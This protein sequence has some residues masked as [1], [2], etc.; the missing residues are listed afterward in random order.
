[1]PNF[2]R[3]RIQQADEVLEQDALAAAAASDDDHG[4]AGFNPKTDSV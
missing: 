1:M 3:T 4:F 2:L